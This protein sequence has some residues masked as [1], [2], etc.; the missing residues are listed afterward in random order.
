MAKKVFHL[1]GDQGSGKTAAAVALAQFFGRNGSVCMLQHD[2][3]GMCRYDR[4]AGDF[5]YAAGANADDA[6][7]L[8]VEH[9]PATF[10]GGLPGDVVMRFDR[11]QPLAAPAAVGQG[12]T[13]V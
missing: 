3:G 4:A 11:V 12:A 2:L 9:Y 1:V 8:F 13:N 5:D 6:D 10:K 7:F